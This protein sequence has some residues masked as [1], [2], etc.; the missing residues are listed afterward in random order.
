MD[1]I[2]SGL[3]NGLYLINF[4]KSFRNKQD[5]NIIIDP[6][7]CL[8]KLSILKFYPVGTKIS[9]NDNAITIL[10]PGFL[11]GTVRFFKGDG[12]EDLHNIYI[13]LIK[14][15]EWYWNKYED[16]KEIKVL[17]DYAVNGLEILKSSYPVNSTICH[18][19]DLYIFHLTTKQTKTLQ[20]KDIIDTNNSTNNSTNIIHDYLKQLWSQREIHIIIELLLE[21][22]NSEKQ[23]LQSI[24]NLTAAKE[25]KFKDFL[26]HHFAS[27]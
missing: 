16:N 23:I 20:N 7:S 10:D 21:Y 25:E 5:K 18:T 6:M 3:S 17:F 11:Q 15:I 13:P 8:I 14:T 24:L 9:V 4:F 2:S 12:R 26:K 19:L 1:I 27:L 22:N